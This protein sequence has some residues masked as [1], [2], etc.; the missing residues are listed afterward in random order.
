MQ[1]L[2]E[3]LEHEHGSQG[4]FEVIARMEIPRTYLKHPLTK[5]PI[6]KAWEI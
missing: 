6:R 2:W 3:T 5:L 1:E 4:F